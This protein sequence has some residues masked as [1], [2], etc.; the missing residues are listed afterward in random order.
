MRRPAPWKAQGPD[1]IHPYWYKRLPRLA[2]ELRGMLLEIL[3]GEKE[4]PNWLVQ[5][6]TV[7]IPKP[8]CNGEVSKHRPIACLNSAYKLFTSFIT[9]KLYYHLTDNGILPLEQRALIRGCF[10]AL[11]IDRAITESR[12][13]ESRNLSVGWIDF[14]KAYD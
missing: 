5:G 4:S 8:G 11:M 10:D 13:V 1:A 14:Q 12:K 7:L 2:K 3:L 9:E 6:R